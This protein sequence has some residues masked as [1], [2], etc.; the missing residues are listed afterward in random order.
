MLKERNW[1]EVLL[2][3]LVSGGLYTTYI[4]F[5]EFRDIVYI[6]SNGKE[7]KE[8]PFIVY[9]LLFLFTG[10]L[11]GFVLMIIYQKKAVSIGDNCGIKIKPRSGFLYA[12][13]MYIP[14]ISFVIGINNHN[15][16]VKSYKENLN[17][18]KDDDNYVVIDD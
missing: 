12:L 9:L 8:T 14:I 13:I 6:E 2:L 4:W 17:F 18:E 5:A 3:S 1:V 15:K 16:L 10:S 7:T 11:Y